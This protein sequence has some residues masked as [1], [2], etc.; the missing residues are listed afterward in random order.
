MTALTGNLC[1]ISSERFEYDVTTGIHST[2]RHRF[3]RRREPVAFVISTSPF[4]LLLLIIR[5]G[6]IS[7]NPGPADVR[8]QYTHR[9]SCTHCGKGVTARSRALSCDNCDQ[10]THLLCARS[11]TPTLYQELCNSGENFDFL[12]NRCSI[13]NLP[14]ADVDDILSLT[15]TPDVSLSLSASISEEEYIF[16]DLRLVRNR[17]RNNVII[18][19]LNINSLRHKFH[20]LS[21]LFSDR[22]VDILFI[23]ETKLDSTFI[24]A[25]FDAPGY[26]SFRKDRNCHGGGL[27][28]YIRSDLPARRRPDL[29]LSRIESVIIEITIHNR[30]WGIIC[31][32]RPPSMNNS[33]FI[34]DFTAGVDRL[35]VHFDNVI[36]AG[37]LNYDFKIPQKYQP[38]QSVCDIF[39]FTNL[40]TKPTCFTKNAPPS[41]VD[42]ILTNRPSFLFNITNI[43]CGISDWHNIIS[44][45]IKG[46]APPPKQRKIKCRS[47][48][49]FDEEAFSEAV[50]VV[51]FQAAYVFDDVDD[52]YWAHEVLFTDILN[53]HA[54]VKEKYVKSK[55]CPFINTKLRK[56]SYKK[57][58][59]FN[60]Y[61]KWRST[62]NWEAYRK[63]RNLTTN[64][65][66]NSVRTYFDERCAG[67]PKSKY[68]WPTVKPFLT[69]KGNFKDPTII[70]SEDNVITSDQTSVSNVL[71][72]FYV[73]VAK[74][75]GTDHTPCDITTHPS[76]HLI[77]SNIPTP[78]PFNFKPISIT[79]E[80]IQ[81]FI[82][83]SGS[84]KATGVDG[85]PA[86][87][88][89]SCSR[90]ISEPLSKLINFSLVTSTFP[91]RLKQAQV[92]PV[93][94]KKD[95]L[96]KHNY[97][98]TSILPF[99]SKLYERSINLQLSA[100][101]E[102]FFNPFLGAFRQGMGCQ[103]T[104][105]RL[106]E[107]WRGALD[108]HEYVAAV[109]MDLSK[110]FDCL[111]HDLL[112]VKLQ[113]YGLSVKA[114]ALIS[115]YLSG[116]RQQVRL[117]PHCSDWCDII[118][119]V[120]Q[121]SILGPLLF[122]IFINDIFHVL[123]RSSL[124]NYADDNTLSYS[125][126]NPITLKQHLQV[127]CVA[128]LHW[129]E[130]N[131]MQA[132]PDKFQAISF[133][134]KGHLCYNRITH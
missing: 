8:R 60:K 13:G 57:A 30:K 124:H 11:M 25:Q 53:E 134:K 15:P 63:Q 76:C 47:Y 93:Y 24:Q 18:S 14:F 71:N 89:K 48:K 114:C 10:W 126:N 92:I 72:D 65:K 49:N 77:T 85:I 132:N 27:L 58:M 113:A 94:K 19:H 42:V 34:D 90:T 117:G 131:N 16:H 64:I 96:D 112:L 6:D 82:S 105:L 70:L 54:P 59:L 51:P 107:D 95:P 106:V 41:I 26:N 118:K 32:Y 69:N 109:L 130:E 46:H 68:F 31:T 40:I 120:P 102:N 12:C 5:G 91:N 84:K 44:V 20:D 74:D 99:V 55:V 38:L 29:E 37:D 133:G 78:I 97:R 79:K 100:H 45:V 73:N 111:P 66:R 81:S 98:P 108:R 22:L 115:S 43:S 87:I 36:V 86:K 4:I 50:G 128:V 1:R 103:S 21:D 52:I 129:F 123:D 56:A 23:S 101:F 33:I 104:L 28:A 9:H 35:H 7:K 83:K 75:I 121:G 88:F 67:G 122:N 110:A 80:N 116:G 127:D 17:C 125:H 61:K 39:D 62:A 2:Y 119:G 3:H